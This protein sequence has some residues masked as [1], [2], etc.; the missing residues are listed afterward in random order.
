MKT[1]TVELYAD[2]APDWHC[3]QSP[4]VWAQTHNFQVK[5]AD[6]LRVKITVELPENPRQFNHDAAVTGEAVV[7][8]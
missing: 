4:N 2:L 6:Y 8:P 5:L 1:R 3:D 7:Q